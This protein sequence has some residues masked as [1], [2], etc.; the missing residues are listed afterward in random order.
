MERVR[1]GPEQIVVPGE[2]EPGNYDILKGYFEAF[3]NGNGKDLYPVFVARNDPEAITR[4]FERKVK[5]FLDSTTIHEPFPDLKKYDLILDLPEDIER[6]CSDF[7]GFRKKSVKE[8]ILANFDFR[9]DWPDFV[10]RYNSG[11]FHPLW[12]HPHSHNELDQIGGG[13]RSEAHRVNFLKSLF[14]MNALTNQQYSSAFERFEQTRER[15]YNSKLQDLESHYKGIRDLSR[16]LL[17]NGAEYLLI[18]GNH[19]AIASTITN[20]EVDS[21]LIK[22]DSDLEES[23]SAINE[24]KVKTFNPGWGSLD[25]MLWSFYDFCKDEIDKTITLKDRVDLLVSNRDLPQNMVDSYL[26]K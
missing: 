9:R 6:P 12:V 3:R 15:A 23:A 20:S 8:A 5:T 19:R 25:N 1:L 13:Q 17:D 22:T 4:G 18:D 11:E 16:S 14:F 21:F 10:Q 2:Y 26:T 24:G 7:D